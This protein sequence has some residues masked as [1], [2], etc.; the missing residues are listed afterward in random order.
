MRRIRWVWVLVFLSGWC[1]CLPL[2]AR[3]EEIDYPAKDLFPL[4]PSLE[5]AVRFWVRVYGVYECNQYVFHDMENLAVVYEVVRI[6]SLDPER[7]DMELGPDQ[8]AFLQVKK[9]FYRRLLETL[10]SPDTDFDRLSP[11][12]KRIFDL[13]GGVRDREVYARAAGNIRAQKGQKNRFRKGLELK[14]RYLEFV[15]RALRSQGIPLELAALPQVESC[16]N[17]MARSSAGAA[18]IWQFTRPTGRLFLR[19]DRTIDER[20]DPIRSSEAAAR[21]LRQ[22]WEE[23]GSWPLAITA[24]NH[25]LGGMKKARAALGTSDIGEIVAR[26]RGPSF[27]FASRNFYAEFLAALHVMEHSVEYFGEIRPEPS[28]RFEEVQLPQPCTFPLVAKRLGVPVA[29]LSALNPGLREPMVTGASR[30]PRGYRLRVPPHS[31]HADL[32]ARL[33]LEAAKTQVGDRPEQKDGNRAV[34]SP[35]NAPK[36][37]VKK[38]E[39]LAREGGGIFGGVATAEASVPESEGESGMPVSVFSAWRPAEIRI[40]SNGPPLA[41][42]TRVEPEE[43]PALYAA[44][45][46]VPVQKVLQWNRLSRGTGLRSGQ[47]VRL[48]FERVTPEEFQKARLTY[49]RKVEENFLKQYKVLSTFSHPLRE[50]ENL[51]VL[52]ESY[53]VPYWLLKRYNADLDSRLPRSGDVI[54]IPVVKGEASPGRQSST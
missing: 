53:K 45:L 8:R 26:Y 29:D 30:L 48:V 25:G 16:Y 37:V 39:S 1:S 35:V 22:H 41:G 3:A 46:G 18:G 12:E 24:Y 6:Q 13:F 28:I 33:S 15:H 10:A 4:P 44:W 21:L 38:P 14:G 54:R 34:P 9:D 36:D 2:P 27:G 11:E 5:N 49:H 47:T 43:T 52:S 32:V 31:G 7:P 51:W 50:G 40:R 19:I 20:L 17:Y 23:L 42:S